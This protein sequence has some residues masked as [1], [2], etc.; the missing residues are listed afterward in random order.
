MLETERRGSLF[1]K[2]APVSMLL[3]IPT[4]EGWKAESRVLKELTHQKIFSQINFLFYF[5][6]RHNLTMFSLSMAESPFTL[7]KEPSLNFPSKTP[8]LTKTTKPGCF[9]GEMNVS[10]ILQS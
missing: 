4:S 3:I 6:A 8:L 1:T 9:T 5:V 2:F 7:F 10:C